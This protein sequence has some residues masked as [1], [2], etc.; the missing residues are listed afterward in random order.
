[1]SW[2]R[3]ASSFGC[4]VTTA[5]IPETGQ[6]PRLLRAEERT[7]SPQ[8]APAGAPHKSLEPVGEGTYPARSPKTEGELE[9]LPSR[10]RHQPPNLF[11]HHYLSPPTGYT[12]PQCQKAGG[13]SL[14]AVGPPL[15]P[16]PRLV[17]RAI[18]LKRGLCKRDL[19]PALRADPNSR[20]AFYPGSA[21][22]PLSSASQ[23]WLADLVKHGPF[24]FAFFI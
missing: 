17:G 8:R 22:P 24:G 16:P 9:R 6:A 4:I 2:G 11:R 23:E 21:T 18:Q 13:T 7:A 19:S 5:I 10:C 3:K 15:P 14:P 1:M 12:S 20:P